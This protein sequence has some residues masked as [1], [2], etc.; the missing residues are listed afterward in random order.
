MGA[1]SAVCSATPV[2]YTGTSTLTAGSP[3]ITSAQFTYDG[4]LALGSRYSQFWIQWSGQLFDWTSTVND[5]D[6]NYGPYDPTGV[7]WASDWALQGSDP[8]GTLRLYFFAHPWASETVGYMLLEISAPVKQRDQVSGSLIFT[9]D[10]SPVPE[11][12][13]ILLSVVGG[14]FLMLGKRRVDRNR[15]ATQTPNQIR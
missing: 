15:K 9:A 8:V 2:F 3:N 4:E 13:S 5:F 11:P 1:L 6:T 10:S 12:S 7:G 14:A